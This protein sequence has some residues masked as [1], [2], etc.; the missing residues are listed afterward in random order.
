MSQNE[1]LDLL[2]AG[3]LVYHGRNPSRHSPR[4]PTISGPAGASTSLAPQ[5]PPHSISF[6]E[7]L[8]IEELQRCS[9]LLTKHNQPEVTTAYAV[10]NDVEILSE[11]L[12]GA[13][14]TPV[15]GDWCLC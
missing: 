13:Q 8:D 6:N 5:S 3:G 2:S 9:V 11:A 12:E 15:T 7:V 14:L 1:E 10:T 4:W